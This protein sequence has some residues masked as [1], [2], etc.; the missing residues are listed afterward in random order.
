MSFFLTMVFVMYAFFRILFLILRLDT[1]IASRFYYAY[2]S[3]FALLLTND[4]F[5]NRVTG[6]EM[7]LIVIFAVS[8]A[9]FIII[10]PIIKNILGLNDNN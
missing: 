8:L 9:S 6:K 2:F 7:Y 1:T 5:L 10:Y 4:T 3:A